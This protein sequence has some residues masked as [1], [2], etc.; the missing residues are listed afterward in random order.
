MFFYKYN[1]V[2]IISD[3]FIKK[4]SSNWS[5]KELSQILIIEIY[6]I[7]NPINLLK[8]NFK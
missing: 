4:S 1:N 8:N 5:L 2:K 7:R 3:I 6:M